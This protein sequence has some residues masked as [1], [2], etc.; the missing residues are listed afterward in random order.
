VVLMTLAG[1][2]LIH[3]A[4]RAYWVGLL[5]LYSVFQGP[6]DLSRMKYGPFQKRTL[7]WNDEAIPA[8]IERADNRATMIFGFGVGLALMMLMPIILMLVALALALVIDIWLPSL[9]AM[10]LAFAITLAPVIVIGVL[11]SIIDQIFGKRINPNGALGK[12]LHKSFVLLN[13]ASINTSGNLLTMYSFAQA[14]NYRSAMF[15]SMLIGALTSTMALMGLPDV[16]QMSTKED[17]NQ[18]WEAADY[19]S[20]RQGKLQFYRRPYIS[21]P[22]VRSDYLEINV[23]VPNKTPSRGHS[24]CSKDDTR[25]VFVECLQR[26][27]V[28]LI[29]DKPIK[30]EWL[31]MP[32]VS[33]QPPTLRAMVDTRDLPR[34]KHLLRINYPFDPK[35]ADDAWFELIHFWK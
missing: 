28:V 4:A 18:G 33:G 27:L 19:A 16:E 2:F 7:P 31:L 6:P 14:R 32:A 23:P 29:N 12:M 35:H 13:R 10:K 30:P 24:P 21:S 20:A 8:H 3:L 22:Q 1:A 26:E 15:A 25:K 34:G 11:P 17:I 5:G 9:D